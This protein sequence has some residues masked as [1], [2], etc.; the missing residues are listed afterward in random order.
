MILLVSFLLV[1]LH[2]S[3][4]WMLM[5][6]F[7]LSSSHKTGRG[8]TVHCSNS[9]RGSNYEQLARQ[10]RQVSDEIAVRISLEETN[11]IGLVCEWN[12]CMNETV[13]IATERTITVN[14]CLNRTLHSVSL[15][16][17]HGVL[18]HFW[19]RDISGKK[20][21]HVCSH[22]WKWREFWFALS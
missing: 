6:P 21:V 13:V 1:I 7:G 9:W 4:L 15:S 14:I 20:S 22:R 11:H 19:N 16:P 5:K 18:T 12:S 10:Q 17:Y 8:F 3:F 2:M